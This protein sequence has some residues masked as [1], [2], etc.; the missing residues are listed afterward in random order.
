VLS[1]HE[2]ESMRRSHAMAPLSASQV[3]LLLDACAQMARERARVAALLKDLPA[4]VA[5]LRSTLNELHRVV[6]ENPR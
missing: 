2:V 6:R 4:T 1:V 3:D 5:A